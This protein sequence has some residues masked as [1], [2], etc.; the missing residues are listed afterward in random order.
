MSSTPWDGP[1]SSKG[2]KIYII[3]DFTQHK[4]VNTW[5]WQKRLTEEECEDLKPNPGKSTHST[6]GGSG[7][8]QGSQWLCCR[9]GVSDLRSLGDCR[10]SPSG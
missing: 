4:H 10:P 6:D 7:A 3:I 8:V 9:S 1:S 2:S 5:D